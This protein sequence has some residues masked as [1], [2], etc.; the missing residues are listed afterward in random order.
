MNEM[1]VYVSATDIARNMQ[2]DAKLTYEILDN[3]SYYLEDNE[4]KFL[5]ELFG[6]IFEEENTI[7]LNFLEKIVK[8]F[9]HLKEDK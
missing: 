3:L 6:Y 8:Q 9:E 5:D 2:G 4:D 1:V 7:V